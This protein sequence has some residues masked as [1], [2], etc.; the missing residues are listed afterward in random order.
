MKE[1]GQKGREWDA[2]RQ[3]KRGKIKGKMNKRVGRIKEKGARGRSK[4]KGTWKF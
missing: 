1:E 4:G 3:T 2:D